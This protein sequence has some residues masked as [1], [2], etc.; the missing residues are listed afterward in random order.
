[1]H[2]IPPATS[3]FSDEERLVLLLSRRDS[4]ERLEPD[5]RRL[6]ARSPSWP[7]VMGLARDHEIY[8]L[9]YLNLQALGFPEVPA[10][11][12]EELARLYGLN[13]VRVVVIRRE[14]VRVLGVLAALGIPAIPWKG[15]VLAEAIYGDA[16]SRV[17]VDI[18]V[19]VPAADVDRAVAALSGERYAPAYATRFISTTRRRSADSHVVLAPGAPPPAPPLEVHWSVLSGRWN[20]RPMQDL[21]RGASPAQVS[22]VD[23]WRMNNDWELLSLVLH[24]SRHHWQPLKFLGDIHHYCVRREIDW[25]AVERTA[26][27]HGWSGPLGVT[28]RQCRRLFAT[29]IPGHVRTVELPSWASPYPDGPTL[30]SLA[31]LRLQLGLLPNLRTRISYVVDALLTPNQAEEQAVP[32]P[33]FLRPLYW[34]IRPVRL[35][36]KYFARP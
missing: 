16:S 2:W 5:L 31:S 30:D 1:V 4:D 23:C 35:A 26:R 10:A 14:T 33:P 25:E 3:E 19:I 15:P 21:W 22:G 12:R 20:Q 24:A 28:V 17:S 6:L 27:R 8:P 29:P 9:A 13:G 7:R 18:D 34:L 36:I 11:V 32:L